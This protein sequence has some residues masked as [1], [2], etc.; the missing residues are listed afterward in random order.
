MFTF[1]F[2]SKNFCIKPFKMYLNTVL[3]QPEFV[4]QIL[5]CP[6]KLNDKVLLKIAIKRQKLV[7]FRQNRLF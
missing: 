4:D 3:L 1:T 2:T 5:N 6:I 7:E